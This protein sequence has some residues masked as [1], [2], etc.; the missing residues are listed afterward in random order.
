MREAWRLACGGAKLEV[1]QSSA[2]T[3]QQHYL[4]P[5]VSDVAHI[6]SRLSI[7]DHGSAWHVDILV[8]AVGAVALVGSAVATMLG[9]DVL[10]VF[11]VQ[12]GPVVVVA[13]Q[14][15]ASAMPTVAPVGSAVGL[16]FHVS[17]VR[18]SPA[19]LS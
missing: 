12:Q 1:A 7:V 9:E 15:D 3:F 6:L 4:L 19:A 18:R 11:Q 10:L 16:V 2:S 8:L 5:V 14:Y 17:E 13:A